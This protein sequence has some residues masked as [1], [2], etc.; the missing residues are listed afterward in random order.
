MAGSRMGASLSMPVTEKWP[1]VSRRR[2]GSGQ[3][4][5]PRHPSTRVVCPSIDPLEQERQQPRDD[6]QQGRHEQKE[7]VPHR[8]FGTPTAR[9]PHL[10][11]RGCG[12]IVANANAGQKPNQR[13]RA[14]R[15]DN[16]FPKL[17]VT[18]RAQ[19]HDAL[20]PRDR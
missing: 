11:L 14:R 3:R 4:I 10:L 5:R 20:Q 9:V 16:L 19:L 15:L 18:S 1:P 7:W 13:P 17:G 6:A 2:P 12:A 8:V